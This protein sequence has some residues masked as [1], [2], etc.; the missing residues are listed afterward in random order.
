M[1]SLLLYHNLSTVD[2]H[3]AC[4]DTE[5]HFFW[6]FSLT[7][8][9]NFIDKHI[10]KYEVLSV[11]LL[12][13]ECYPLFY[14]FSRKYKKPF[15]VVFLWKE[16]CASESSNKSAGG[17]GT[18][19]GICPSAAHTAHLQDNKSSV[20]WEDSNCENERD[21]QE[22]PSSQ[23]CHNPPT[24]VLLFISLP[25]MKLLLFGRAPQGVRIS[26]PHFFLILHLSKF[27]PVVSS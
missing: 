7:K 19:P 15:F 9:A 12:L 3:G 24:E 11:M 4:F 16:M 23:T 25:E 5:G 27:P 10:D 18:L 17:A 2:A 22:S 26:L 8:A 20:T 6:L 1:K 21:A 13:C 14:V